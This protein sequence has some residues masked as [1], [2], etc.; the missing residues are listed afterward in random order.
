MANDPPPNNVLTSKLDRAAPRFRSNLQ[1]ALALIASI[2]AEE[3]I[4]RQGGGETAAKSQRAKGRLTVRDR[5]ALL[6]DP[7]T[8]LLELGLWAAHGM[9]EEYGGAP[10]AGGVAGIGP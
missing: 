8:E 2:R 7:G 1:A 9:Y 10:C 4:I 6:L 3:A 5:L